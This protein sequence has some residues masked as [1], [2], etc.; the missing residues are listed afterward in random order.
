[1][2][3]SSSQPPGPS[4][5]AIAKVKA[6]A[7]GTFT[8]EPIAARVRSKS[9][10]RARKVPAAVTEFVALGQPQQTRNPYKATYKA[11]Y[12]GSEKYRSVRS[13]SRSVGSRDVD[14]S[15]G[16]TRERERERE[17]ERER[18]ALPEPKITLSK[19]RSSRADVA[20]EKKTS[21]ST[22]YSHHHSKD[23]RRSRSP[24]SRRERAQ[25]KSKS[26]KAS[27]KRTSPS[28]SL[29]PS[30]PPR[31]ER[32]HERHRS[33]KSKSRRRDKD[34]S[35]RG[36]SKSRARS[37]TTSRAVNSDIDD[38]TETTKQNL[39]KARRALRDLQEKLTDLTE[40]IESKTH[41]IKHMELDLEVLEKRKQ[42]DQEHGK[43]TY[44]ASPTAAP[45]PVPPQTI[46]DSGSD[47]RRRSVSRA[48]AS[49]KRPCIVDTDESDDD[50][51]VILDPVKVKEEKKMLKRP[52]SVSRTRNI[53]S[54]THPPAEP[55]TPADTSLSENIVRA[56]SSTEIPDHFWGKADT[57]KLLAQHRVRTIPDGS[58]RK[59][60]HL[61]FNPMKPDIFATSSDDGGLILWNY[62]RP[63]HEISK[64]VSFAPNSF[65]QDNQCAES[66]V[67]SPDGNRLAIAFRDPMDGRGEFCIVRLHQLELTDSNKPQKIPS[68]RV[69]STTSTQH[70][71]GISAI[72]WIP[73]GYGSDVTSHRL[74]TAGSDHAVV[75]W[76]ED[77]NMKSGQNYKWKI[78]H[79]EHRSEVKT[80]CVHSQ[81][82][83]VF[84]GSFDGQVI[85][86]DMGKFLPHTVMERR[87]PTISKINAVLEHPHNPNILLVSSVEQSEHSILLHDLRERYV[88]S[89]NSTMTLSWVKSSD[90]KSMSQYIVPRWSPAGMHV[91]CGSKSGLVNI[92]DVRVRG[93][94][95]PVV[96]PQQ[97]IAVHQKTV[98]HATWHPRYNAIFSVSNDR[99]LGLLTFR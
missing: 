67:W 84:T 19:S 25:S 75:L 47:R 28:S 27:A 83:A 37:V 78:L 42:I 90:A 89:R 5:A 71:R 4:A 38:E 54:T 58:V 29:S 20:Q 61:A 26:C 73:T 7:R 40:R 44:M 60:R 30:P 23:S 34:E 69:S 21:K 59:G 55:V 2:P 76:E 33:S 8:V 72:E 15:R 9:K 1:M 92:W 41:Q 91:S 10:S 52:R 96:L 63:N 56:Y 81:R 53:A 62:E 17:L 70:S 14:E 77:E 51:V 82:Q 39:H 32:E 80:I 11:T 16:R 3:A 49:S 31:R 35:R 57:P 68:D 6:A 18:E 43:S 36:K 13:R 48:R 85:R 87:K 93:P 97:S 79:R 66:I 86:Y 50:E 98:L 12:H 46:S 94:S 99:T 45:V 65:R 95:F 88:S 22:S 64:L 24:S 74:V